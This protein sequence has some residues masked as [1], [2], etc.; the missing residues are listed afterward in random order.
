MHDL[1][2][3]DSRSNEPAAS[4]RCGPRIAPSLDR[5]GNSATLCANDVYFPA[6]SLVLLQSRHSSAKPDQ[7]TGQRRAG[8]RKE[9]GEIAASSFDVIS[10]PA[11]AGTNPFVQRAIVDAGLCEYKPYKAP[12]ETP[13]LPDSP[14]ADDLKL[15]AEYKPYK[16]PDLPKIGACRAS[17]GRPSLPF[18]PP[19]PERPTSLPQ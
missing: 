12:D 1:L 16:A 5:W 13:W 8:S 11:R 14:A 9:R 10:D 15:V 17:A 7:A 6:F 18:S 3:E 4:I 19:A 2:G